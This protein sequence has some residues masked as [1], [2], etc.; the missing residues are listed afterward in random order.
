MKRTLLSVS[1][2]LILPGLALAQGETRERRS[3]DQDSSA[4]GTSTIRNRVVGPR[5]NHAESQKTN[6]EPSDKPVAPVSGGSRGAA[7]ESPKWGNATVPTR[8]VAREAIPSSVASDVNV[9]NTSQNYSKPMSQAANGVSELRVASAPSEI[10]RRQPSLSSPAAPTTTY[11]VGVGDVLDIRLSNLPTREST[12]F[13]VQKGGTLE[14][15]LL[16]NPITVAGLTTDEI[17]GL[18]NNQIR[19]IQAARVSVSVR[20]YA[21]HSVQITGLVDNPGRKILRRE[22]MPLYT[23]LAEAL[24][25]PEATTITIVRA[26]KEQSVSLNTDEAM[27][28]LVQPDDVIRVSGSESIQ[29]RFIYVVGEVGTPGE[30]EFHDGM[31]LTQALMSAGGARPGKNS[32]RVSRRNANGFLTSSDYNLQ[33]IESGKSPDPVIAAGDRIEVMR[34][35]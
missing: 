31:T 26:G 13:T 19:V 22:A 1:L 27:A 16:S 20:D 2:L 3:T 34:G 10:D 7:P 11:R 32:A 21:S 29:R 14:Y 33:S 23:V 4:S 28:T 18:L 25:R 30:R 35:S 9:P 17:S 8:S 5:A 24:A 15:P 6:D 12:L